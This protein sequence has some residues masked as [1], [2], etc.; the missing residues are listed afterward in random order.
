MMPQPCR[1]T[2]KKN[3]YLFHLWMK[4]DSAICLN[5]Q[6]EGISE[7]VELNFMMLTRQDQNTLII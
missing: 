2:K 1:D 5:C 7:E 3:K 4:L 6:V